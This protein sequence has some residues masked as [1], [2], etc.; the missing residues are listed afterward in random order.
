MISAGEILGRLHAA[1][2]PQGWWPAA[3]RFEVMVGAV[4][5]QRTNWRN[6]E[7]AL[8]GLRRVGLLQASALATAA[9]AEIE[10]CVRPAGFFRSKARRL[11][12]L[13]TFLANDRSLDELAATSTAELR[14][15]L[16]ALEGIGP[17][18][19]DC[20]LL[21]AFERPA[22]VVDGYLRRLVSRLGRDLIPPND[23]ALRG[24]VER[25]RLQVR[26]L[27]EMHALVVAH[28]RSICASRHD[29]SSCTLR[30][31]CR[32][33]RQTSE[34]KLGQRVRNVTENA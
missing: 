13:G 8:A 19:A 16:L 11:R 22:I 7:T 28:G 26:E 34:P 15:T 2:G 20:I 18:T 21:Y 10:A 30:S 33:A 4:L 14:E 9:A 29:C 24:W 5:V 32:T 27:N 1:H 6:A 23:A 17:E 3:D 25:D 31:D 12:L